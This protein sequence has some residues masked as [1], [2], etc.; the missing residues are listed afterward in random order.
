MGYNGVVVLIW[1]GHRRYVSH[2]PRLGLWMS[3]HYITYPV[4]DTLSIQ[5]ALV[6][7]FTCIVSYMVT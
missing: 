3:M 1:A 7:G 2:T 6:A 4:N 5:A